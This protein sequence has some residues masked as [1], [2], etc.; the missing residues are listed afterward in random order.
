MRFFEEIANREDRNET[1]IVLYPEGLFYKAY[2]RSAFACV[3]RVS[4]FK[5]SKKRIKYC[6]RDLVSIGFPAAAIG[7][8]FPGAPQPLSDGR[9]VIALEDRIDTKAC[10]AWKTSLPLKERRPRGSGRAKVPLSGPEAEARTG[11]LF[12]RPADLL[13]D[14]PETGTADATREWRPE[15][16]GDISGPGG[17]GRNEIER[18]CFGNETKL[19]GLRETD[20]DLRNGPPAMPAS[21][22][23]P[24]QRTGAEHPGRATGGK[25]GVGR[26]NPT[27]EPTRGGEAGDGRT[28]PMRRPTWRE[29]IAW[30]FGAPGRGANRHETE[31]MRTGR[32]D[33][34]MPDGELRYGY[35]R[36]TELSDP[37]DPR[38]SWP[39]CNG[40]GAGQPEPAGADGASDMAQAASREA[41]AERLVRRVREFRLEAA[42]PVECL[43]FVADLKREIDGYL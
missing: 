25:G 10:H 14:A 2:D 21:H 9:V 40:G 31:P 17:P 13:P 4:S 15:G 1:Q 5:P 16:S 37:S 32:S 11:N 42:T 35:G 39:N 26:E 38:R 34:K 33:A 8:Y 29:R 30:L 7:K 3:S 27:P 24:M 23:Q 18:T 19:Q 22:E 20:R 36:A 12:L 6:N 28:T 43:L 41:Q